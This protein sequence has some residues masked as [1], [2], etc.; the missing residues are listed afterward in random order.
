MA[1][2]VSTISPVQFLEKEKTLLLDSLKESCGNE[3]CGCVLT[4][5]PILQWQ[6]DR[7][8]DDAVLPDRFPKIGFAPYI[9]GF[10]LFLPWTGMPVLKVLSILRT[11]H[12]ERWCLRCLAC[13]GHIYSDS[14]EYMPEFRRWRAGI[15]SPRTRDKLIGLRGNP[16]RKVIMPW[17]VDELEDD[18]VEYLLGIRRNHR[19]KLKGL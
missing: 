15:F 11:R 18:V 8:R 14:V 16:N 10:T 1:R 2:S 6:N 17:I 4:V 7:G 19:R 3:Y 12:S 5:L 9:P 13:L